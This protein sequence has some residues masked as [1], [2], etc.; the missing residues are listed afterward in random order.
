MTRSL[1]AWYLL[2]KSERKAKTQ[3]PAEWKRTESICNSSW[4]DLKKF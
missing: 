1:R 4:Q 3:I 2:T